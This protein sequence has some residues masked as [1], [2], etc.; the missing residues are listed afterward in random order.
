M[1]MTVRAC[2]D[3]N[4]DRANIGLTETPRQR[5]QHEVIGPQH[6]PLQAVRPGRMQVGLEHP[7]HQELGQRRAVQAVEQPAQRLD[8][9]GPE[10]LRRADAIENEGPVNRETGVILG[11]TTGAL[12]GGALTLRRRTR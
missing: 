1:A 2:P 5:G 9:V 6:V 10:H 12:I 8:Q 7:A 11:F 4:S 3:L